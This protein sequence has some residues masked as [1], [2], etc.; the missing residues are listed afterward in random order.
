VTPNGCDVKVNGSDSSYKPNDLKADKTYYVW[1]QACNSNNV[2]SA[3]AKTSFK[4][5]K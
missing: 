1:V 5:K 4:T 2:C 3:A